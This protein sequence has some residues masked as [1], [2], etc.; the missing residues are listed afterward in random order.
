MKSLENKLQEE[1]DLN[2]NKF[3]LQPRDLIPCYGFF[4]YLFREQSEKTGDKLILR[5]IAILSGYNAL[6][7]FPLTYLLTKL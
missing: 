2:D 1:I 7:Y 6:Y 5:R 4:R 3:K